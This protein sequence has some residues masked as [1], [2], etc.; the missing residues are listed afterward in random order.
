M[1]VVTRRRKPS[2]RYQT[3]TFRGT[4]G[5]VLRYSDI[6]CN[7]EYKFISDLEYDKFQGQVDSEEL[8]LKMNSFLKCP[9][10]KTLWLFW[11]G[12]GKEPEQY[13]PYQQQGTALI[14]VGVFCF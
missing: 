11:N 6:P 1:N 13:V 14:Y 3:Q 7:I 2:G 8:Y 12:S 9:N 10:C 5:L 4:C